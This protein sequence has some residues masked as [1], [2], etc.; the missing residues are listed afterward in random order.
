MLSKPFKSIYFS[1]KPISKASRSVFALRERDSYKGGKLNFEPKKSLKI[2]NMSLKQGNNPEDICLLP[3]EEKK[4]KSMVSMFL[5]K[6]NIF[7]KKR[8]PEKRPLANNTKKE[9][10]SAYAGHHAPRPHTI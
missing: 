2:A 10:F 9:C 8:T 4:P 7:L 1:A 5:E 6:E 3:E